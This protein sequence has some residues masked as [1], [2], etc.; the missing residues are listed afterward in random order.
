MDSYIRLI[1]N[2]NNLDFQRALCI[3]TKSSNLKDVFSN[4]SLLNLLTYIYNIHTNEFKLSSSS[5]GYQNFTDTNLKGFLHSIRP[6][7]RNYFIE[8][9]ASFVQF[10]T[11]N[12]NLNNKYSL[13]SF[14][15]IKLKKDEYYFVVLYIIPKVVDSKIVEFYFI[16]LPL[17]IY[18]NEVLIINVLK[19]FKNDYYNTCQIRSKIQLENILTEEQ[20]KIANLLY[21]G[22]SSKIIAEKLN[23]KHDNI[24]KYNIRI[25]DRLS[26]FLRDYKILYFISVNY[27]I[28]HGFCV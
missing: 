4:H 24:L 6:C 25:K 27:F 8:S 20:T 19:K 10:L 17:K 3:E 15:P 13:Q 16:L 1:S 5:F 12:R 2:I 18:N 11:E 21:K 9:F 7:F 22:Y 14:L 28:K 23:K 26:N